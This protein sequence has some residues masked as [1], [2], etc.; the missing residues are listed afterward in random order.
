[1]APEASRTPSEWVGTILEKGVGNGG[2]GGKVPPNGRYGVL[3]AC[4]KMQ[5]LRP[6]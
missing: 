3:V 2:C 4:C 1:M 6:S 5:H